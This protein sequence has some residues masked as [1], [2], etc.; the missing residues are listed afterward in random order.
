MLSAAV[1]DRYVGEYH[2]AA[3]GQTVTLRRDGDRLLM[4]VQVD[5]S[6]RP[7]V[8]LS[9]TRF[10]LGPMIVEFSS[11]AIVRRFFATFPVS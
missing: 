8:A 11:A 3:A 7:L 4:K 1:L 2:Y 5:F 6:E 10:S 9:E